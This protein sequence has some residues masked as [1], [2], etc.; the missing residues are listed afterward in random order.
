MTSSYGYSSGSPWCHLCKKWIKRFLLLMS[1]RKSRRQLCHS[2]LLTLWFSRRSLSIFLINRPGGPFFSSPSTLL[3]L[4]PHDAPA[5]K[6][7]HRSRPSNVASAK[8]AASTWLYQRPSASLRYPA[9]PVSLSLITLDLYFR[10]HVF[11][12]VHRCSSLVF[13]YSLLP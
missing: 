2:P 11:I 9:H 4:L 10:V 8:A 1:S 3:L 12:C 7:C 13:P 6:L 5:L